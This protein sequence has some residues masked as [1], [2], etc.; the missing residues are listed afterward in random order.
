[1][2]TVREEED[3][4]H[5][6][7]HYIVSDAYFL[8]RR[9]LGGGRGR[10]SYNTTQV[11]EEERPF[12][13]YLVAHTCAVFIDAPLEVLRKRCGDPREEVRAAANF[14]CPREEERDT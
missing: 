8:V 3:R 13:V 10:R 12:A 9:P 4:T 2:C 11:R 6:V 1:M 7:S 5:D 14:R